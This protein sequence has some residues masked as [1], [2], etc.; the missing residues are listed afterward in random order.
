MRHIGSIGRRSLPAPG[1]CRRSSRRARVGEQAGQ[2]GPRQPAWHWVLLAPRLVVCMALRALAVMTLRGHAALD[3]T[4][5][6]T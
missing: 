2:V 5:T 4:A 6:T 1:R 3:T